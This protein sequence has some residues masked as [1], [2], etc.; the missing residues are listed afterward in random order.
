MGDEDAAVVSGQLCCCCSCY[1]GYRW[2]LRLRL[3]SCWRA[4]GTHYALIC[5]F[6]HTHALSVRQLKCVCMLNMHN[7]INKHTDT[8]TVAHS[9]FGTLHIDISIFKWT[10]FVMANRYKYNLN[11][12][13]SLIFN[14]HTI[15][16]H[17][18]ETI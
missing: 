15:Y 10:W 14:M 3:R 6:T 12:Y 16:I 9:L 17:I 18:N 4:T 11:A 8:C 1:Y 7:Y 13:F 2:R 5:H